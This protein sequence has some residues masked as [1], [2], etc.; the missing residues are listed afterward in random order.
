MFDMP[1][2]SNTKKISQSFWNMWLDETKST[3]NSLFMVIAKNYYGSFLAAGLFKLIN[4]ISQFMLPIMLKYLLN[5][6]SSY[7]TD[8]PE[9]PLY[10]IYYAFLMLLFSMIRSFS[11]NQHFN[12]SNFAAMGIRAGLVS[13]IYKKSTLLSSK[14]K[15]SFT[16]GDII[17]RMSVDSQ[18]IY[19]FIQYSQNIWS[20]PFQIILALYLSY[21]TL[22]W[23]AIVGVVVMILSIPLNAVIA[24]WVQSLEQEQMKNKDKR[25]RLTQEALQGVKI[26]KLYAWETP[27]LDRIRD[28]RNRL[29][30]GSLKKFGVINS[31][32]SII[33]VFIPF[34]VTLLTFATYAIFDG[35]SRGPLDLNLIFVSIA[36]FNLLQFPLIIMPFCLNLLIEAKVGLERINSFL[37]CEELE[38]NSITRI[39]LEGDSLDSNASSENNF[40]NSTFV[41]PKSLNYENLISIINADFW[42]DY[43]PNENRPTLSNISLVVGKNELVSVVGKVGSGKSSL[44]HALLGEMYKSA[45]SATIVG[46]VALVPQQP[47]IMNCS[48]RENILFGLD[49]DEEFYNKV[50]YACSLVHDFSLLPNGDKSEIGEKG[51][52][53]SGGQKARLSL[54][55]AVYSRSD[56]YLLDDPLS[57]VDVHVGFHLFKHV[58]GPEGMLKSKSRL[59]VTN[60]ISY[61][62]HSDSIILMQDGSILDHNNFDSL[63]QN[64]KIFSKLISDFGSKSHI[65]SSRNNSRANLNSTLAES[66]STSSDSENRDFSAKI[67]D[68]IILNSIP[69]ATMHSINSEKKPS[70]GQLRRNST[71]QKSSEVD[72]IFSNDGDLIAEETSES[73]SVDR[74][75]YYAYM[76]SCGITFFI[77]FVFAFIVSE[78]LIVMNIVWLKYWGNS[79]ESGENRLFFY[80][81]IYFIIGIIYS[82]LVGIRQYLLMSV[83]S[84]QSSKNTHENM[85][86]SI[87]NSPMSFFDT[88]PQ[89]RIINRFSKDQSTI[90]AELPFSISEWL[91]ELLNIASNAVAITFALP[92]FFLFAIPAGMIFLKLQSIYLE[93]SRELKRLDSVSKSPI[94]QNFQETLDGISTI[95]S[96]SQ[97]ERFEEIGRNRLN[98]NQKVIYT[99]YALNRWNSLRLDFISSFM[100]FFIALVSILLLTQFEGYGFVNAGSIGSA[101]TFAFSITQ[102]LSWCIRM[103]CKVETDIVSLERI[104]EYSN[105]PSEKSNPQDSESGMQLIDS[106]WPKNGNVDFSN[107]STAYREGLDPVLKNINIKINSGE[108]IGVVGRTGAGKSSLSLGLF[109]IIEPTCGSIFIDDIDITKLPLHQLRS[110]L[111]IIP[112]DPLLFSGSIRFNLDPINSRSGSSSESSYNLPS[113]EDL[114]NAL[115]MVNLKP[116][117]LSL[118]SGL[119]SNVLPGGENFSVGQRQ[120]MC[121]ARAIIR[122]SKILLLDEATAAIDPQTDHLIQE[123]IRKVFSKDTIITIAH[124]INTILDSDR[125]LVLSNGEVVEFDSPEVLIKNNKST[126]S[127]ILEQFNSN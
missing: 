55:R 7:S 1:S 28:V 66:S 10:G 100:I 68:S 71:V 97:T 84:I 8:T 125:I 50:V 102:S 48:A 109:R 112:Q 11:L 43:N 95:R 33:Y 105:L 57:A 62:H 104:N 89:G 36:A 76:K 122:K 18:R 32:Q 16:S 34:L 74:K 80:L 75:I 82:A 108:K 42:W 65:G 78:A 45:G 35:E 53:L 25:V 117:V 92:V 106:E 110:R 73:G 124:R 79:N 9:N 24:N 91:T 121:L 86:K 94:Y 58:L 113:D 90:D 118:D 2:V 29:E 61:L 27:F 37:L 31:I 101:L 67:P 126:F 77:L 47:W 12:F 114:W 52:N 123:T 56:I 115:E 59:L 3:R 15:S 83:C 70:I 19:E 119:D 40:E 81:G 96:Y 88:T 14:S 30:L 23:S 6:V 54:A 21:S 44:I 63:Y 26:L 93:V 60:A 85:L 116:F 87:F 4:D 17:N 39:T 69:D 49:Y 13:N 72:S 20:S 111:S 46:S 98:I 103:Y 107:Y 120:L 38:K 51:V 127:K 99:F 41:N 5:F 64:N 22:G